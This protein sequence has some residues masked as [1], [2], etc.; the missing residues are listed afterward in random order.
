MS[1]KQRR[2][3][4]TGKFNTDYD[5]GGLFELVA[6]VA[7]VARPA[8]PE[9]CSQPKW[10]QARQQAGEPKAPSARAIYARLKRPWPEILEIALN[11]ERKAANTIGATDRAK[12]RKLKPEE[13][14]FALR[15]VARELDSN[16]FSFFDYERIRA[17]LLKRDRVR[18]GT[19][20][21][22]E[23]LLPTAARIETQIGGWNEALATA[24]L[25]PYV[26][27][28]AERNAL[29]FQEAYD[30]FIDVA[31]AEPSRIDIDSLR[32]RHGISIERGP[33]GAFEAIAAGLRAAREARGLSIPDRRLTK[34]ERNELVIADDVLARL[35]RK[36]EKERW[37][38]QL[39]LEKLAEYLQLPGNHTLKRYQG[40][41]ARH[42]WPT[43]RAVARHASFGAMISSARV[44][45]QTGEIVPI[46]ETKAKAREKAR[47]AA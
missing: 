44:L 41:Y 19:H 12:A 29:T 8:D 11:P 28:Q 18:N 7:R 5:T 33:A 21:V 3:T 22:M 47:K 1:D 20:G 24:D 14:R 15:L 16:T 39:C 46:A 27:A 42:G 43:A 45:I 26:Q 36:E 30:L 34:K 38:Y 25:R 9:K 17:A 2:S 35:P 4:K 31:G 40:I 37:P 6:K 23:H 32:Q 13:I 10:D